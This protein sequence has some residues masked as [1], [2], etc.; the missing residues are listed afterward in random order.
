MHNKEENASL[1]P[2]LSLKAAFLAYIVV[3]FIFLLVPT[4]VANSA[5]IIGEFNDVKSLIY[6][7]PGLILSS[8]LIAFYTVTIGFIPHVLP[9]VPFAIFTNYM[10]HYFNKTQLLYFII[11]P[12]FLGPAFHIF[13]VILSDYIIKGSN[14]LEHLAIDPFMLFII[15]VGGVFAG[16]IYWKIMYSHAPPKKMV[17]GE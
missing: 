3:A 7:L 5:E 13:L 17:S 14:S 12:V 6:G 2:Y 8:F 9:M 16:F 4:L 1:I 15:A 10:L 11:L